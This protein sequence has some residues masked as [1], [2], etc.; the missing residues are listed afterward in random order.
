MATNENI[1]IRPATRRDVGRLAELHAEALLAGVAGTG[2]G[3]NLRGL[4]AVERLAYWREAVEFG[5]PQVHVATSGGTDAAAIVGFVGF[6]RSRD[7][8]TPPTMGE[9][10]ALFVAPEHWARGIGRLLCEAALQGLREEGCTEVTVWVPSSNGRAIRFHEQAGFERESGKIRTA[11]ASSGVAGMQ[12]MR[13]HRTL[14]GQG[15]GED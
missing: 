8:G 3:A 1:Q 7:D 9:L 2:P 11:S 13:L 5:E 12:E 6:D 15:V 10:W 4:P 14:Q